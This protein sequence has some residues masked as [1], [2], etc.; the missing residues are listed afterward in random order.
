VARQR[1]TAYVDES[2]RPGRELLTVVVVGAQEQPPA[3][4][5]LCGLR[6]N[7]EAQ[8]HFAHESDRRRRQLLAAMVAIDATA[9][10]LIARSVEGRS[11]T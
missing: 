2:Q 4:Q 11:A 6:L 8:I 1:S 5:H 10:T 9:V 3:R 7:N